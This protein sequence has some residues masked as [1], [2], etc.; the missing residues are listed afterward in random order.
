MTMPGQN[1]PQ[2]LNEPEHL[3]AEGYL[4]RALRR[5]GEG[6]GPFVYEKTRD[7]DLIVDSEK[8][9]VTRDLSIIFGKMEQNWNRF[10][11]SPD[12]WN[13]M[14]LLIGFRN[15]PW[16]HMTG[17]SDED[18]HDCLGYIRKFL[19]AVSA[20][21]QAQAVEQMWSEL[22]KLIFRDTQPTSH[23]EASEV[24]EPRQLIE[25]L[26]RMTLQ[27]FSTLQT[28]MSRVMKQMEGSGFTAPPISSTHY[29]V[30]SESPSPAESDATIP[31]NPN[32]KN[33]EYFQSEAL[34]A[35]EES[36]FD[37]AIEFCTQVIVL[38]PNLAAELNPIL[39][40]AYNNRGNVYTDQEEY[41]QAIADYSEALQRD[42]DFEIAYNNRGVAFANQ[43]EYDRAIADYNEALQHE[44]DY[45]VA[46]NNRGNAY[47]EKGE[48]DRAIADYGEV[49]RLDPEDAETYKIRGSAYFSIREHNRAIDDYSEALRLN[50][51]DSN[52]HLFRGLYYLSRGNNRGAKEDYDLA[53][54]DFERG[55]ELAPDDTDFLA[56]RESAIRWRDRVFEYDQHIEEN[57]D[58][59]E[60]WYLR[61]LYYLDSEDYDRAIADFTEA[62]TRGGDNAEVWNDRGWAY[63]QQG[64]DD[65]AYDD[66][67]KTIELKPDFANAWYNR[68]WV[69]RRRGD[70]GNAI[71]DFS[72]AI[73]IKQ[74]Y[75]AAYQ[76]RGISYFDTGDQD[77]AQDDFEMA[78]SLGFR[79]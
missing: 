72:Q 71:I 32:T 65:L 6:L 7:K 67:S 13:Y 10:G 52:A 34:A 61:G 54:L 69:W 27:Q 17:Y 20:D 29:T 43:G 51:E 33:P 41:D 50:P 3:E 64:E 70:H 18:V 26:P 25:L 63:W 53:I 49:L 68:A 5:L 9:I 59:L 8:L 14:G 48:Y 75:A 79:P 77:R 23:R 76:H 28:E 35:F 47:T 73:A 30:D 19:R 74:D 45:S 11:L 39:V 66:Y 22:G 60:G 15:G 42:P 56:F 1:E 21:Q 12:E 62:I 40:M 16:A 31:L 24:S 4:N 38:A 2:R 55:S 36:D 44:P 46:Y 58:D 78:R 57:P 37:R